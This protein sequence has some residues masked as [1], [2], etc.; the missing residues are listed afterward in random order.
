MSFGLCSECG[1][2]LKCDLSNEETYG[3]VYCPHC[4]LISHK[5]EEAKKLQYMIE[6]SRRPLLR[7]AS[8]NYERLGTD[9]T[10]LTAIKDRSGQERVAG[11]LWLDRQRQKSRSSRG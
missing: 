5:T 6:T 2:T 3:E 7:Q 1:A 8:P 9:Q 4:G 11:A 10:S